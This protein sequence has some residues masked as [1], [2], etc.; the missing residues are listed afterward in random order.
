MPAAPDRPFSSML[1]CEIRFG[2]RVSDVQRQGDRIAGLVINAREEVRVDHLLLA[3]G[4]NADDT[5][6]MLHAR[7]VQIA[8][9]P[10]ALGLRLE[11]PQLLINVPRIP[12]AG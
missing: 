6:R 7:G 9:K 2:A 10:F 5:Y 12:S 11:Y 4:Q 8:P 3:I 1:G